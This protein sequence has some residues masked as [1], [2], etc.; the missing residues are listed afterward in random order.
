MA[1]VK[2]QELCCGLSHVSKFHLH[3][4]PSWRGYHLSSMGKIERLFQHGAAMVDLGL[5]S[6]TEDKCVVKK[7]IGIVLNMLA[8]F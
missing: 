8:Y 1:F 2:H 5:K 4:S 7:Q 6:V 3:N